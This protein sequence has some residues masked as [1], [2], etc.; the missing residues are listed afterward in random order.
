M[1]EEQDCQPQAK[2]LKMLED[3]REEALYD[4][5]ASDVDSLNIL[6]KLAEPHANTD[7]EHR[8]VRHIKKRVEQL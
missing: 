3:Q 7:E 2:F 5:V 4:L 6:I 8:A 1:S